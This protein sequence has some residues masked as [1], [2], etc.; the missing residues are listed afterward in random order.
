MRIVYLER[1]DDRGST[2]TQKHFRPFA[3][4]VLVDKRPWADFLSE[5]FL[6]LSLKRHMPRH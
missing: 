4:S 2:V 3:E 6:S 5:M 1:L